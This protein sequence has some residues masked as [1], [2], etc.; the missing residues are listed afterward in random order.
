MISN[1][2][3]HP[4]SRGCRQPGRL[5]HR[6]AVAPAAVR[7]RPRVRLA[8]GGRRPAAPEA[9]NQTCPCGAVAEDRRPMCRKCRDRESWNRRQRFDQYPRSTSP[10]RSRHGRAGSRNGNHLREQEEV[11]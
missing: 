5:Q 2:Q 1:R 9:I 7:H 3:S 4:V 11:N 8:L 10:P 6:K